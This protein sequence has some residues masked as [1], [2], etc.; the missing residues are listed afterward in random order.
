LPGYSTT[1]NRQNI[2]QETIASHHGM[3]TIGNRTKK[4]P[5][6][7]RIAR[8]VVRKTSENYEARI[9]HIRSDISRFS[10]GTLVR[11]SG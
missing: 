2:A 3:N 9:S 6:S 7:S 4:A 8:N 5:K 1:I 11:F 10:G